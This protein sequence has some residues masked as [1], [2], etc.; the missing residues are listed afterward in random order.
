MVP[1]TNSN[2]EC[3]E[4]EKQHQRPIHQALMPF[5]D[6]ILRGAIW[7]HFD[8]QG[9]PWFCVSFS[10]ARRDSASGLWAYR[11][12]FQPDELPPLARL[13]EVTHRTIVSGK[14]SGGADDE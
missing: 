9:H 5:A 4:K 2:G 11:S 7:R 14:V 13:V 6:G 8:D 12:F 3:M 1:S 10:R